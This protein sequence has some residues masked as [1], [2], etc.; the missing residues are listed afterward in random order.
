MLYKFLGIKKPLSKDDKLI[1]EFIDKAE[2]ITILFDKKI[3]WNII[4]TFN[5]IEMI[6][7]LLKDTLITDLDIRVQKALNDKMLE[8]EKNE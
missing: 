6:F 7:K 1:I 2:K 5:S 4:I 8:L 3:R